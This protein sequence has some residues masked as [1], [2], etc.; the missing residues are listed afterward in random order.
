M[1]I[2]PSC[3]YLFNMQSSSRPR[4][5]PWTTVRTCDITL[6]AVSSRGW[7]WIFMMSVFP[8]PIGSS[9]QYQPTHIQT[10]ST[11]TH[12]K[13]KKHTHTTAWTW[14]VTLLILIGLPS[15]VLQFRNFIY[16]FLIVFYFIYTDYSKPFC[17]KVVPCRRNRLPE[18]WC[19]SNTFFLLIFY[20]LM[21]PPCDG[22][23]F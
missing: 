13:K 1:Y 8:W 21:S 5:W 7:A 23:V 22:E 17:G 20:P 4:K 11:Q 6:A 2:S 12:L 9:C 19:T 10:N 16:L 14:S 15:L 3:P 18:Y